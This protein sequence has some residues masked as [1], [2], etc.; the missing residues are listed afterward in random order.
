MPLL[1]VVIIRWL[2]GKGLVIVVGATLAVGSFAL[3]MYLSEHVQR[4]SERIQE[5]EL[6][7]MEV[8]S[9]Q[10]SIESSQA[11]I[12]EIG[13]D[14]A[15]A[16]E[17]I[18]AANRAIEAVRGIMSKIEYVFLSAKEQ[19]E[20]D[21][22]LR[23]SKKIKDAQELLARKLTSEN[24][25]L[26]DDLPRLHVKL[27]IAEQQARNL[28][29]SES[30]PAQYIIQSW[31]RLQPYL[32]GSVALI[33]FGPLIYKGSAY[34][35]IA[36]FLA[37]SKP[38]QFIDTGGENPSVSASTVSAVVDLKP[39]ARAWVKEAY[40]QAS[41]ESLQKRT[42]FVLD[43]KIPITC[44]ASGL[45]ELIEFRALKEDQGGVIT[46]STQDRPDMEVCT[47]R[48]SEKSSL[49]LRP[50]HIAGLVSRT[51]DPVRIT[52]HWR[53]FHAQSWITMQFRYFEVEGPCS[54]LIAGIRGVRAEVLTTIQTKG[55]RAN[56]E[57]TIGFTPGLAYNAARAETFWSYLRGLNPLFD[58]IYLGDGVFLCQEISSRQN[59]P[60]GRKFWSGLWDGMLKILGV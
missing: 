7:Q 17:Q 9:L 38:I 21:R 39:E 15:A 1:I 37:T 14:L 35:I 16:R 59:A 50:S 24:E 41:D 36:P 31:R 57:A 32:I 27:S 4:E 28:M 8:K 51:G 34:Y 52:R 3:Y 26:L 12:A 19:Y 55:R 44:L 30:S 29:V 47:A 33:V 20:H 25:N 54:V 56:Q 23:T 45:T 2:T 40:L 42:R 48:L 58:D 43:W 13:N 49:V 60:A 46:V 18:K 53:V 11:R 6:Y 5:L 10:A 22:K